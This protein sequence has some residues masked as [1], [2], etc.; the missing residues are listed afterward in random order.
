MA[1]RALQSAG[2]EWDGRGMKE[3]TLLRANLYLP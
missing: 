1:P 3:T 2:R